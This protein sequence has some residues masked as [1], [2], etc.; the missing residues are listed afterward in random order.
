M[1]LR[2]IYETV[3]AKGI[4]KDPRGKDTVKKTLEKRVK[5]YENMKE[6]EKEFF[7]TE[8]LAN[9]YA[10]TRILNG[11]GDED[12]KTALVGI[13]ME[14][15]EILLADR[16]SSKGQKIDLVISH[17]PEGK[18]YANFYEVMHMQADILNKFGV[19]INVAESLLENRIKEVERRLSPVNHTRAVDVAKLLN[20][21][22]LCVHTPADNM[23]ASYLQRV[24]DEKKP[25]TLEDITKI[26]KEI[27]EYREAAKNNAGPKILLGSKDRRAGKIFVD[28]TGGTEGAKDIFENLVNSGVNTIVV[29]HL[30]EDHRKEAEKYHMNAV[31]AGHIS[32]D[33]LGMNLMFDEIQKTDSLEVLPCSGYRR[34]SRD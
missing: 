7:D 22:F 6:D 1:L 24:F 29:M 16:L 34:F 26:L 21:P 20:V 9:P 25:D 18:A 14:M 32:S 19:P 3:V 5:T 13:D 2:K 31:L 27:P 8:S 23:V 10:D 15:A 4:E 11:T 28:M 33:N 12:I 17:H 30:S